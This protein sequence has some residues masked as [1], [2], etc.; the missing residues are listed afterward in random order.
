MAVSFS[1]FIAK[2]WLKPLPSPLP[3]MPSPFT[4]FFMALYSPKPRGSLHVTAI[5]CGGSWVKKNCRLKRWDAVGDGLEGA[6]YGL[7][8]KLAT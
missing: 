5:R 7:W 6:I 1:L 3:D 8:S 2:S 4:L